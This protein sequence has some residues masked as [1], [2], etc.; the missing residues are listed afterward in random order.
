MKKE[1]EKKLVILQIYTMDENDSS[2]DE[3]CTYPL[4]RNAQTPPALAST[5]NEGDAPE[6][7]RTTHFRIYRIHPGTTPQMVMDG[8]FNTVIK[9]HP[10]LILKDVFYAVVPDTRFK[11]RFD[12]VF[13]KPEFKV[14]L[15]KHGCQIGQSTIRGR[16]TEFTRVYIPNAPI[17]VG[18]AQIEDVLGF[19]GESQNTSYKVD[20][21]GIR[22]GGVVSFIKPHA[23]ETIPNFVKLAGQW[24]ALLYNGRPTRCNKC[25]DRTH[26]GSCT[27]PKASPV[28]PPQQPSPQPAEDTQNPPSDPPI[29]TE[30]A[31]TAVE[32][33]NAQL[34]A[35]EKSNVQLEDPHNETPT[36]ASPPPSEKEKTTNANVHPA[37]ATPPSEKEDHDEEA[38]TPP[39]TP[40]KQAEKIP[41]RT[42]RR[43]KR[44]AVM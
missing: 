16:M 20:K 28:K 8:I 35:V 13:Q 41:T 22:I 23:N 36:E 11:G 4:Q 1:K 21:N 30:P 37:T 31:N 9:Y 29:N 43:K 26:P 19:Y 39:K 3:S 5:V 32:D 27:T 40:A 38:T 15:V 12:V 44:N 2:S 18:R 17:W 42:K 10:K 33:T 34:E 14:T 24:C 6:L 25:N 7:F